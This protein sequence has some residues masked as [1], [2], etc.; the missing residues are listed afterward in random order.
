MD[1]VI[2]LDRFAFA[3]TYGSLDATGRLALDGSG[4]EVTATGEGLDLDVLSFEGAGASLPRTD[5]DIRL[6]GR[7]LSPAAMAASLDGTVLLASDDGV[8]DSRTL[9]LLGGDFLAGL[10]QRVNPV[11]ATRTSAEIECA[12]L[13]ARA[14]DG[15]LELEPGIVVR[16]DRAHIL[17]SGTLDL[18]DER[19]D[20][21]L[22]TRAR[23]GIGLSAGSIVTPFLRIG[24]TLAGP[25]IRADATGGAVQ[26]GAAAATGGISL[27]ARGLY[28]RV[29]GG[30]ELC[31]QY[32]AALSDQSASS[33]ES[34][35]PR[36]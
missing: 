31:Q 23:R 13:A 9:Q 19:L 18:E 27:L 35:S 12:V 29:R 8:I 2:E 15:D 30:A 7:G 25:R 5:V 16:S 10:V 36:R 20:L 21:S 28:E 6:T 11:A 1:G 26:L 14:E 32:R 17:L 34:A 24:G 22:A 33:P 3:D 4:F